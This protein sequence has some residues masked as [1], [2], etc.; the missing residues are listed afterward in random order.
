MKLGVARQLLAAARLLVA[1]DSKKA[2][3]STKGI[4]SRAMTRLVKPLPTSL[5]AIHPSDWEL[6]KPLVEI[7]GYV[8]P[9]TVTVQQR[10][11]SESDVMLTLTLSITLTEEGAGPMTL[12][13]DLDEHVRQVGVLDLE[14]SAITPSSIVDFVRPHI[15]KSVDMDTTV[16]WGFADETWAVGLSRNA[17]GH[18]AIDHAK[19][20]FENAVQ[21]GVEP[22]MRAERS[23]VEDDVEDQLQAAWAK[24]QDEHDGVDDED[25]YQ[26][27]VDHYDEQ[28]QSRL[29]DLE[30]VE[31]RVRAEVASS[32]ETSYGANDGSCTINE[33]IPHHPLPA[34]RKQLI[35]EKLLL[36]PRDIIVLD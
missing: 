25:A 11:T 28:K 26:R 7:R 23:A 35:M 3:T 36:R 14:G 17:V 16:Y 34:K 13:A 29:K 30:E 6:S 24:W 15:E 21:E 5:A 22:R 8:Y 20:S 19:A 27:I 10:L 4:L 31:Q 32:L 12:H 9:K 2:I 33:L 18:W 1:A